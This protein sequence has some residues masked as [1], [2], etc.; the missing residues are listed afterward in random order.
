MKSPLDD[1]PPSN[2]VI[3]AILYQHG[4]SLTVLFDLLVSKGIL[5]KD[6]IRQHAT[7]MNHRLFHPDGTDL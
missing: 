1:S 3:R 6:E 2:P 4:L 5:T 7:A